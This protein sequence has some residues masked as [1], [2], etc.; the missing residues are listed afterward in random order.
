MRKIAACYWG[1][2]AL[3]TLLWLAANPVLPSGFFAWRSALSQ[4]SGVLGMAVMSVAM[5]LAMRPTWL[6]GRLGGLDKMYRLHKWLGIAALVVS[7]AH[8]AV[9]Q[10][11]KWL[12]ALGLLSGGR[13]RRPP[14]PALD[15][16]SLQQLFQ[17]WRHSAQGLGEWAFYAAA[18][19]LVLALLRRVPYR[20][21]AKL[22]RLLP[23]AYLV[24]VFH[25]AVLLDFGNWATPS[26]WLLAAL[27]AGGSVSAVLSLCRRH[28][29]QPRVGGHIT[30]LDYQPLL[31]VLAVDVQLDGRWPGHQAGQFAFIRFDADEG[32]HPFTLASAWQGD[33]RVRI[34]IKALGDYTRQLP[35]RLAVGGTVQLEGPYGRFTFDTATGGGERRQIW[36]AGGIGIT[37]FLA[38]MQALAAAPAA[39]RIDFFHASSADDALIRQQLQQDASAAGVALHLLWQRSDGRLD[40]ERLARTVPDWRNADIWFCGPAGMGQQLRDGLLAMGLPAGRFHQELF[41]MR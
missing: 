1:A 3:L 4:Y 6:E 20:Y 30:A 32:A 8:W 34:L 15:A 17:Q 14:M 36:V 12:R 24:L 19:L 11:P 2:L 16:D 35:Q 33:G 9:S 23:L 21:F 26:G 31:Q 25:S 39:Q 37:P 38:R 29:G 13:P 18:A 22:H 40:A 28:I 10:G 41:Q 7:I 5:L 27:M